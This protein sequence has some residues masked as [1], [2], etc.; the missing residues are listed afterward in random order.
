MASN[1]DTVVLLSGSGTTF[2]N[3]YDLSRQG[4][5]A[6]N[7]KGVIA[8]RPDA[9]GIQRARS[10]GIPAR[11]VN[12]KD[13]LDAQAFSDQVVK[14]LRAIKPDLVVMAG[15]M[16]LL[17]LPEFYIG[18]TINIHPALLPKF[19]GQGMY[20][21]NV[22]KAVIQAGAKESGC[23]VHYVNNEYD[24]GPIILQRKVAVESDDTPETLQNRVQVIEREAYPEAINMIADGRVRFEEGQAV[25]ADTVA[26]A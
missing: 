1:L 19:G 25:F 16:C 3:L 15:W 8:S 6:A 21:I 10:A 11:V 4:V 17:H 7:I 24:D 12:R 2:Q 14:M 23:T 22:H 26:S 5:L 13:F 20:G 18:K 9:F